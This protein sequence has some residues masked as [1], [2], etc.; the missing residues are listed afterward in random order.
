MFSFDSIKNITRIDG[1]ALV[2]KTQ[3]EVTLHEVRLVWMTQPSTTLYQ[4]QRA[5][6]YDVNRSAFD[7][8][9]PTTLRSVSHRC[10]KWSGSR[11]RVSPLLPSVQ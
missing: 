4:N 5:Y 7:T 8:T 11:R 3:E 10:R 6:S 1:G 9:S 2:V